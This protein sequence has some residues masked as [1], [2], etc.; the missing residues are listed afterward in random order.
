MARLKKSFSSQ[1]ALIERW[2]SQTQEYGRCKAFGW[3]SMH[4]K[5][6]TLF[7]T[8]SAH[9]AGEYYPLARYAGQNVVL[10]N[11]T[12]ASMG[13]HSYHRPAVQ[14]ALKKDPLLKIFA[15]ETDVMFKGP[16]EVLPCLIERH[17]R[18]MQIAKRSRTHLSYRMA[19]MDECARQ[20]REYADHYGLPE[21]VLLDFDKKSVEQKLRYRQA[22]QA[23][24][25]ARTIQQRGW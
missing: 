20:A 6:D 3:E 12:K 4:F 19:V 22:K 5:N 17:S 23:A 16:L 1:R 8:I 2:M 9:G 14:Q 15:V 25:R 24:V 10:V 18:A 13:V 7:S 21:C 11:C